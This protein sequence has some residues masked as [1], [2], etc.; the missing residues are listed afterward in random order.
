M[1][2]SSLNTFLSLTFAPLFVLALRFFEFENV[3]LSFT[4]LMFIYLVFVLIT[5]QN[6]KSI[7]T[8]F[9]YFVLVLIA[10]YY[11]SIEFVKLA[12]TFISGAFFIFFL[13]AYIQKKSI[14]L[15]MMK[16][17]YKKELG[18]TKEN[19]IAQSDGYWAFI[20]FINTLI[21][22]FFVFYDN[23]A[24]WAFYSSVGWYLLMLFALI[25]QILYGNIFLFREKQ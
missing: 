16:R 20:L 6:L 25:L 4:F 12:P 21:Q 13:N 11:S 10:Y 18:E 2:T 23:N 5:K 15:K 7:A 8:P 14:V 22:L 19:Y 17:F 3:A 1:N 24:L 9:I